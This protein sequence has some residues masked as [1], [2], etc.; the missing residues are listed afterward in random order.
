MFAKLMGLATIS[1]ADLN[2]LIQ[3]QTV[4]VFDVNSPQSWLKAHVP[5]AVNLDPVAFQE[6]DLPPDKAAT[7][8]FYCSNPLCRKAPNAAVRAKKMGYSNVK[9]MPAG[10][11]GWLGANL[12]TQ[13]AA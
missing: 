6:S 12:G 11:S 10:I 1:P 2:A 5:T 3:R 9:V 7:L 4:A 13:S 8:V